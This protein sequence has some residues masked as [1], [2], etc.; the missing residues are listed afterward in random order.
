MLTWQK[1]IHV[2]V[3]I[4]L[5]TVLTVSSNEDAE[6]TAPNRIRI[7]CWCCNQQIQALLMNSGI[8]G[9]AI[10]LVG[11]VPVRVIGSVNKGQPSV[12]F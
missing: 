12:C 5:G 7:Y 9:Q 2:I 6:L 3:N 10:A 11:R 1:N 4:R 8:Q